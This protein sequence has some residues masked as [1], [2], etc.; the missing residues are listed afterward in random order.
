ML[1]ANQSR[2]SSAPASFA[3][4][5]AL[6]IP[7]LAAAGPTW[8]ADHMVLDA[9]L[10]GARV[11]VA[12]QS[13]RLLAYSPDEAQAA[14]LVELTAEEGLQP[15]VFAALA[16]SPSQNVCVAA[17]TDGSLHIVDLTTDLITRVID[18]KG[19]GPAQATLF[20][21]EHHLLIGD[22]RGELSLLDLRDDRELFRRQLEY[23]PVYDL[24]LSPD[25]A[26]AAVSF[27]SSRI[28]VVAARTGEHIRRLDGHREAVNS[29]AWMDD[30]RIV[31]GSKD[32]S[33]L[34][35]T[36]DGSKPIQLHKG[37]T[38]ISAVA[39]D[40]GR[41]AFATNTI[42]LLSPGEAPASLEAHSA[43]V[44]VLTFLD[45]GRLLSTGYDARIIVWDLPQELDP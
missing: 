25:S 26:R 3:L 5:A 40:Q 4:A 41:V 44:Q 28:H 9:E 29:V 2:R 15:P 18:R 6:L 31:S 7:S 20:L 39:A 32:K 12:S 14:I 37:D 42:T 30:E 21:D 17:S 27:R 8:R 45:E 35:W 38:W 13:G 33:V 34:L 24:S 22:L 23:D 36:L 11:L 16:V 43:P 1:G 10:A 19:F